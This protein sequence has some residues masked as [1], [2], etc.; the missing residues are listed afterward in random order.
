MKTH[1]WLTIPIKMAAEIILTS[2][3]IIS[4]IAF[5]KTFLFF[6]KPQWFQVFLQRLQELLVNLMNIK[7]IRVRVSQFKNQNLLDAMAEPYFYSAS[8]LICVF[9]LSVFVGVFLSL[10]VSILPMKMQNIVKAIAFF[11]ES[12]P[13]VILIFS[14]QLGIIWIFKKSAIMIVNPIGYMENIYLLPILV[15]SIIPSI[16]LFRMTS[17]GIVVEKT[18][19]YVEFAKS[20]GMTHLGILTYH[21]FRNVCLVVFANVQLILWVIIS[22]LLI[23]EYI[24]NMKGIFSFMFRHLNSPEVLAVCLLFIFIPFYFI[25]YFGRGVSHWISGQEQKGVEGHV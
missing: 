25:D 14:I 18:K 20:K 23:T 5:S 3:I 21:I 22:N 16:M 15:T 6:M 19:S 4:I 7:N 13:D 24:F 17:F 8:I 2:S 9:I 1:H 10:C 12:I 11:L